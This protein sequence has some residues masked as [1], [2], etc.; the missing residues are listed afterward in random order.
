MSGV[1]LSK[2]TL[3]GCSVSLVMGFSY[4]L[5]WKPQPAESRSTAAR[6]AKPNRF[7][8]RNIATLLLNT[9]HL[10]SASLLPQ[11]AEILRD[12]YGRASVSENRRSRHHPLDTRPY[13]FPHIIARHSAVDLDREL[14]TAFPLARRQPP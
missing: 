1:A 8:V 9:N 13:H 11:L 4:F 5:R 7:A 6:P 2:R 14:Q 10:S 12:V 3:S